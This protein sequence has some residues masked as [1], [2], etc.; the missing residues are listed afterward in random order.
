MKDMRGADIA[1]T[2]LTGARI[3]RVRVSNARMRMLDASGAV[4]R[5]IDLSGASIDGQIDGLSIN[6]VEV[7]PLIE[8]ELAR[9]E[10]A[11]ALRQSSDPADL[12]EAWRLVQDA[13]ARTYARVDD[14][15]MLADESVD[16]EWSLTQT[17]RHL[18]S[19][20]DFWLGGVLGTEPRYHPWGLP[21]TGYE[22]F[23][24]G[25]AE[26]LGLDVSASP[27]Y[28]EVRRVRLERVAMVG[29]FLADATP[30]RLAV[31]VESP[32]WMQG[33]TVSLLRCVRVVLN[34]EIEH[35]RFVE[36]DLAQLAT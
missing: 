32:P 16:D 7:A 8:A 18:V 5:D 27:S 35:H 11:R 29:A 2:D 3:Q 26:T 33:E 14:Q 31:E 22:E 34:E 23:V 36:R 10:P 24:P 25:G 17:L 4:M 19:A 9:R 20:T 21:F 1:E 6:G 15:P 28:D 30:E 13:W 12:R